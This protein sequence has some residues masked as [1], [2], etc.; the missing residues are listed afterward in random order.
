MNMLLYPVNIFS[1]SISLKNGIFFGIFDFKITF[2]LTK[3]PQ[4][5]K[6]LF[7]LKLK[8]LKLKN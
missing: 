8:K 2:W 4:E 3:L 5:N 6:I 7:S 1:I